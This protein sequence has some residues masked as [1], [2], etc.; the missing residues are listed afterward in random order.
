MNTRLLLYVK[1]AYQRGHKNIV[2]KYLEIK[3]NTILLINQQCIKM[4]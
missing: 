1:Y 3:R 2:A 4:H